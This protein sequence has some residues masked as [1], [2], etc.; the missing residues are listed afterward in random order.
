[1]TQC[2]AKR[3]FFFS[4]FYL[5]LTDCSKEKCR[6]TSE[7]VWRFAGGR[8]GCSPPPGLYINKKKLQPHIPDSQHE[9][10]EFVYI[11]FKFSRT[12]PHCVFQSIRSATLARMENHWL[13]PCNRCRLSLAALS[14]DRPLP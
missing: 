3:L 6:F 1:M 9:P 10:P 12:N 2:I 4:K 11:F 7:D 8:F 14:Q 5:Y 13:S